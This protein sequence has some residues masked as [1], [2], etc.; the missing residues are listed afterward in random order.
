M[1]ITDAAG[2]PYPFVQLPAPG[3]TDFTR[4]QA[5]V[6]DRAPTLRLDRTRLDN[7]SL[8]FQVLVPGPTPGD[9]W[10][11]GA[12][13]ARCRLPTNDHPTGSWHVCHPEDGPQIELNTAQ[14]CA[15]FLSVVPNFAG[16]WHEV[17]GQW[18]AARGELFAS[19]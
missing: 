12:Y 2:N 4:M 3:P 6:A 19:E 16:G 11:I 7:G 10:T 1:R 8:V 9:H 17:W 13:I 18:M 14:Q 5:A 15:K